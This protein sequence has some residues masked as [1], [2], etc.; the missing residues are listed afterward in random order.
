MLVLFETIYPIVIKHLV[1]DHLNLKVQLRIA[2]WAAECLRPPVRKRLAYLLTRASQRTD[3]SPSDHV[4]Y[5]FVRKR[6]YD[7]SAVSNARLADLPSEF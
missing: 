4:F 5:V 3:L 1:L 6:A 2:N 7:A